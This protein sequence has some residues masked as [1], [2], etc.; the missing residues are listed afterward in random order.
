MEG[1]VVSGTNIYETEGAKRASQHFDREE[2]F[3]DDS[4]ADEEDNNAFNMGNVPSW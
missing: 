3:F 2:I 1:A 4:K